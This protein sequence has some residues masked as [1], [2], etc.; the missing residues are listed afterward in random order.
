MLSVLM[1][2]FYNVHCTVQYRLHHKVLIQY[3]LSTTM[4]V[5]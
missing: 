2:F 5:P 4:Y 1:F 3:I